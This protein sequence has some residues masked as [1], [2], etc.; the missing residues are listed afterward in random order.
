[1]KLNGCDHKWVDMEDGSLDKFCV[2]CSQKAKQAVNYLPTLMND[3]D[4]AISQSV[5]KPVLRETVRINMGGNLGSVDVYKDKLLEEIN[6]S[7]RLAPR[8]LR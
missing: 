5:A 2:R 1:M 4:G 7:L 3:A 8:M 6:K